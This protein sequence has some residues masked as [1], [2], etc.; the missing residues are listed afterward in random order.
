VAAVGS[1]L[2]ATGRHGVRQVQREPV[3]VPVYIRQWAS[4]CR[5]E[6][7]CVCAGARARVWVWGCWRW[8]E[9]EGSAEAETA[10][11]PKLLPDVQPPPAI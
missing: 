3:F 8:P 5:R 4:Y 1:L 6:C 2:A 11:A 9:T 10:V 7:A